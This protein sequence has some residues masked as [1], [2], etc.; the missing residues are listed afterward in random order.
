MDRL[1]DPF[2]LLGQTLLPPPAADDLPIPRP[3]R[4]HWA[5]KVFD[6]KHP[7]TKLKH[8]RVSQCFA[9]P[10][11]ESALNIPTGS[12]ALFKCHFDGNL[13]SIIV[14]L[15]P[16]TAD[17]PRILCR[18]VDH[19]GV[20][21]YAT[22]GVHELCVRRSGSSLQF[23]RWSAQKHK[24]KLWVALFF[25]YWEKMVLFH[26]TFVA[27]KARC[28]LTLACDPEEFVLGHEKKLFQGRIVDD[29]FNHVL[30][31]YEDRS[32]LGVRLQATARDGPL[33]RTPVWTAFV[34]S[35]SSAS[36][37]KWM[38]RRDRTT[39]SLRDLEPLYVFCDQYRPRNQRDVETGEF[40]LCFTDE[41]FADAFQR[42]FFKK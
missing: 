16:D 38:R 7:R 4:A 12:I 30:T 26:D 11:A 19:D 20:P 1:F 23:R 41:E 29:E 2:I 8:Q 24:P 17:Q 6:S 39:I 3:E 37:A 42:A 35:D 21:A 14:Y 5:E 32:C 31:V 13:L 34:S 15:H 33:K 10:T 27:L 28:P 36:P 22:R 18:W 40:E 25:K 9:R